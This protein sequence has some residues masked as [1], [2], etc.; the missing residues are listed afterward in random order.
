MR[1][2]PSSAI[3][4]DST[5]R[6]FAVQRDAGVRKHRGVAKATWELAHWAKRGVKIFE[7]HPPL[8]DIKALGVSDVKSHKKRGL[9][10]ADQ[11][12]RERRCRTPRHAA[13][14]HDELRLR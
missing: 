8:E 13:T 3:P 11:R 2:P 1:S 10:V 9:I 7:Y 14:R 12:R 6:G 4:H 5:P